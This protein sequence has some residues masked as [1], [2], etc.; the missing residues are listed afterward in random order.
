MLSR[1]ESH[2]QRHLIIAASGRVKLLASVAN[3]FDQPA[4]NIHVHIFKRLLPFKL[5]LADFFQ[6]L[7][8]APNQRGGFI[9]RDNALAAKHLR[10]SPGSLYIFLI[11]GPVIVLGICKF[12]HAGRGAGRKAAAPG[13]VGPLSGILPGRGGFFAIWKIAAILH[14]SGLFSL[15]RTNQGAGH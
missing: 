7:A 1:I 14:F 15:A 8:K 2:V 12:H 6:H 5:A 10:M 9:G 3:N 11:H 4:F 13:L